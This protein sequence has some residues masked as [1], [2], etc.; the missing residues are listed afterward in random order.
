MEELKQ[1]YFHIK[2][3]KFVSV[4]KKDN[5]IT[6]LMKVWPDKNT[7]DVKQA[8]LTIHFIDGVSESQSANELFSYMSRYVQAHEKMNQ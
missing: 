4:N 1:V 8:D 3:L 6:I 2:K 5:E 7:K